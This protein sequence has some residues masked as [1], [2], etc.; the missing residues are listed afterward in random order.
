VAGPV[1]FERRVFPVGAPMDLVS[2]ASTP[3][4]LT[5]TVASV[6]ASVPTTGPGYVIFDLGL[7]T[8]DA[9]RWSSRSGNT[10]TVPDTQS[11]G[12]AGTTPSGHSPG[13]GNV[14]FGFLATDFD[15]ANYWVNQL[16]QVQA[17]GD[18]YQGAGDNLLS[19]TPIGSEGQRWVVSG[20]VGDWGDPELPAAASNGYVLVLVAGA[21]QWQAPFN[22]VLATNQ[23]PSWTGGAG[24]STA[25]ASPGAVS[26]TYA[27]LTFTAPPSGN[28]EL[29]F[30]GMEVNF[31]D[32]FYHSV[33]WKNRSGGATIGGVY[34]DNDND[35]QGLTNGAALKHPIVI[36]VVTGLTPGQS[37]TLDL[38]HQMNGGTQ[39]VQIYDCYVK[40]TAV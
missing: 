36:Q 4:D 16:A 30:T 24:L 25:T 38:W 31:T 40:A 33:W 32:G 9:T 19:V 11:R 6:P 35:A 12:C 28:V 1:Q 7:A 5:F 26:S 29:L 21:P 17:P 23:S 3:T 15:E 8:E 39:G 10:F 37:Y 2:G 27:T 34:R 14:V 13:T 18:M 20:G 22:P